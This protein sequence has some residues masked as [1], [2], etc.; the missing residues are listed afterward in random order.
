MRHVKHLIC[1][2]CGRQQQALPSTCTCAACAG[3]LEVV[4]DYDRVA[5]KVNR[6]YFR[7]LREYSLWRYL[8]LLP[9]EP[10]TPRT[11]LRVGFTPI[12]EAPALAG[13]LGL[14]TLL[15][16]DE[17][18]NP[19]GSLKDRAAAVGM[20][21]AMEAGENAVACA[22]T[23]NAASALAGNAAAL[24]RRACIFVPQRAP[25]GK[26][27]QL[28]VFGATV[29]SVQGSYLEAIELSRQAIKEY[30]WY[31]HNAAINP[32]L[33][34]GKKTV[35]L[36]ICEQLD[37]QVPDWVVFAVGD[38]CTIAG[39][40][41]GFVDAY[42]IGL[43]DRLPKMLGVQAAGSCPISNAFH[44]GEAL[45]PMEERTL[46][47][48]IAV[49]APLNPD[50]ALRAVRDSGGTMATVSDEEILQA[51]SLLGRKAGV[52]GEPAGVA[53]LAG[54]RQALDQGRIGRQERVLLCVTGNGLK[55]VYSAGQA[56]GE[57]LSVKPNLRDLAAAL[58]K[59][60]L[61]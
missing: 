51:M 8:P 14:D 30:G 17:G 40:W 50:K 38:G 35:S 57:P 16:K 1:L 10:H 60:L 3:I 52:F 9:V 48:S 7:D 22:S 4:Y 56:V 24:G 27:A 37:W 58:P 21:K 55:D 59:E 41:K 36:E 13:I 47:D 15:I 26:I 45:L 32:Y 54:L 20:A 46:A 28:L 23:G 2:H 53:G 29:V 43:I 5:E 12:Y 44:S 6:E 25:R 39:A 61:G 33:V 19:T 42:S 34:E 49:G 11:P 18:Q 31:N